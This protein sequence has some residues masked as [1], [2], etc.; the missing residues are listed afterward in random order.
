MQK[1]LQNEDYCG[2][3]KN[4]KINKTGQYSIIWGVY[5]LNYNALDCVI[6]VI[7]PVYNVEA[8]LNEC[9]DSIIRQSYTNI[10]IILVDDGSPDNCPAI[11]DAYAEQDYRVRVIHQENGGLAAARNSGVKN[12]SGEYLA[13]VDSD[14]Y[15]AGD[16]IEQMYDCIVENQ[17]DIVCCGMTVIGSNRSLISFPDETASFSTDRIKLLVQESGTGDYYMNKLFRRSLFEGF[18]L[19]VGKLYEDIFSMH[20]LFEKAQTVAWINKSLYYYRINESGISHNKVLSLRFLDYV[21][22]NQ[23]QYEYIADHFQT[24][25]S[26]SMRKYA[27][28]IAHGAEVLSK[29]AD[30]VQFHEGMNAIVPLARAIRDGIIENENCSSQLK[31]EISVISKGSRNWRTYFSRREKIKRLHNFPGIQKKLVTILHWD[32]V[33]VED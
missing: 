11:C 13:F 5:V 21:Y 16:F 22:A 31:F 29:R 2:G 30:A 33:P 26:L 12:A 15:I 7:I 3:R 17:A 23:A 25:R 14:D 9:I 32:F 20:F 24:F 28:A 8:Y 1:R 6:S 10:E 27:G 18:E 4:F 19:P